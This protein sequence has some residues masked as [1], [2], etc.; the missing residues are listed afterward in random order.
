MAFG[1]RKFHSVFRESDKDEWGKPVGEWKARFLPLEL[2]AADE[3]LTEAQ[4]SYALLENEQSRYPKPDAEERRAYKELA[5][6]I[7]KYG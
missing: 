1:R 6:C 5:R 4:L 2:D 7:K 3:V